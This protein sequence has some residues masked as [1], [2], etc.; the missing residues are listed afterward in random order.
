MHRLRTPIVA[1]TEVM[2]KVKT[3]EVSNEKDEENAIKAVKPLP[4]ILKPSP[5]FPSEIDEEGK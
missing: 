2:L 4:P 5:P 3:R 1:E